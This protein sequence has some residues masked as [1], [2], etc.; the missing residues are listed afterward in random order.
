MLFLKPEF[1]QYTLIDTGNN[2]KLEKFGDYIVD[3][4]EPQAIW[5]PQ[6][7]QLELQKKADAA[8][9]RDKNN[10]EKGEW[11]KYS[12]IPD[13]WEINYT[14][15]AL[16]IKFNLAL[17]GFKHV[18]I[19]P[20][21]APNWEY[22]A[23]YITHYS[24]ENNPKK[25]LNLFAYTGG[26]SLAAKYAGADVVHLDAVKQ[27]VSW[28]KKN[29]QMSGLKDIRWLIE[30]AL[31]FVKREV[32]RGNTYDGIILDPPSYGRGPKGEKWVIEDMLCELLHGVQMILKEHTSFVIKFGYLHLF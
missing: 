14:S 20:E 10:P 28:A 7:S 24:K 29:M 22:I 31:T 5:A 4:P 15:T 18:G 16:K 21:Q 27:T 17:T 6:L 26:A 30:D 2:R 12:K 25:I 13:T 19:F 9:F 1:P 8:F 23:D 3:R 11:K 32:K